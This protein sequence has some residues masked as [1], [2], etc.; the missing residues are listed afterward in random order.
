MLNFTKLEP[1]SNRD[2]SWLKLR[3]V[4]DIQRAGTRDVSYAWYTHVCTWIDTACKSN[5]TRLL[6]YATW[7]LN[8]FGVLSRMEWN[9]IGDPHFLSMFSSPGADL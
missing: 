9:P 5:G 2:F 7:L 3:N 6:Q 4:A 8:F 1:F